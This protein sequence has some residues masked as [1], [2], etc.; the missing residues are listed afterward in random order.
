LPRHERPVQT[1]SYPEVSVVNTPPVPPGRPDPD[2]LERDPTGIRALLGALPDP[3]P[4]PADLVDRI[5]ASI[6]AEQTSRQPGAVV[7]PLAPRRRTWLRAG[8][9][10]AA[11]AAVAVSIP[12]LMSTWGPGGG[13]TAS[14][15]ARESVA[16]S[17]AGGMGAQPPV[18]TFTSG[19]TGHAR[20][21]KSVGDIRLQASGTAYTAS[22]LATQ[23][24][25]LSD[26]TDQ[27]TAPAASLAAAGAS[28]ARLRECLTALGVD[29]WAPVAG[30]VATFEGD[31]AIVVVVST[32]TGQRV[33]AVST[34]CRAADPRVLSGPVALP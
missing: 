5:N 33:Y 23:A 26:T 17:A 13:D 22:G 16:D 4:M 6:A 31:P 25:H 12:A 9:A 2:D 1:T 30:D 8:M 21:S 7:V 14:S 11:V 32:D 15:F 24:R 20:A 3:G 28:A 19:A 29:T 27:A 34:H 18:G 10:A